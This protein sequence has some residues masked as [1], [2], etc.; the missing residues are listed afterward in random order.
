MIILKEITISAYEKMKLVGN[1]IPT[2]TFRRER[3]IRVNKY[4]YYIELNRELTSYEK[5]RD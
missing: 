5:N 3:L 2:Q 4:N 1:A